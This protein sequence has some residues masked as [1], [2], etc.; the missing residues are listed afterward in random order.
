MK[1]SAS[2]VTYNSVSDVDGVI[3]DLM[4]SDCYPNIDIYVI[5]NCSTDNT[6]Q[7][8]KS[9][10][11]SIKVVPNNINGGYGY[12]HNTVINWIDSDIHLIINPDIRFDG[13]LIRKI[14]EYL[15][16]NDEV[17]MCTPEMILESGEYVFPPKSQPKLHYIVGRYLKNVKMLS[18]WRDKYTMKNSVVNSNKSPF[19]IGFCSGAFMAIKTKYYKM[20]KGFDD[21]YF[22]YYEDADLTRKISQYGK[23]MCVPTLLIVHEGKREAYHSKRSRKTMISSMIK[24]FNK[25]GWE[26]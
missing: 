15:T 12:G 10:F 17:S 25:W 11:P 8:I 20:V 6:V 5:D 18:G 3:K 23:C 2:I 4:N 1:I 26:L 22:L 24:Y 13:T 16:N 9:H 21:R 14:A 7:H 19:E